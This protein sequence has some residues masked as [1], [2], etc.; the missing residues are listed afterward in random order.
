[1]SARREELYERLIDTRSLP[2]GP[3][4]VAATEAALADIEAAGERGLLP[5]AYHTL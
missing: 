5:F 3:A 4:R 2:E 1:M